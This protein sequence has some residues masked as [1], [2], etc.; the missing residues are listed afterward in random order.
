MSGISYHRPTWP[1][2]GKGIPDQLR[3][4]RV[5][6]EPERTGGGCRARPSVRIRKMKD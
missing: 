4:E 6:S 1:P 3:D 2:L 5:F